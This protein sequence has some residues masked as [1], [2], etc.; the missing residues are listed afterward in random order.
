MT[1]LIPLLV[2]AC[3]A[4]RTPSLGRQPAD[5]AQLVQPLTWEELYRATPLR[6]PPVLAA[7]PAPWHEADALRQGEQLYTVNCAPCHQANGEGNLN[8][9]PALNNNALVT[10][11]APQAFIATVAYGRGVM[12]AFAPSLDEQELAAV[13]SYVR[14]AWDNEAAVIHPSQVRE[15]QAAGQTAAGQ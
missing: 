11:Q 14:S 1:L 6:S 7:T 4:T 5:A 3:Q 8:R 9:F 2:T 13:L 10:A 15:V 12:P